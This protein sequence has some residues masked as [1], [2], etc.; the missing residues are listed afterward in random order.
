MEENCVLQA[1]LV[2]P[3]TAPSL[4]LFRSSA[5]LSGLLQT[6]RPEGAGGGRCSQAV[7]LKLG[8]GGGG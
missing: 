8:S 7:A 1:A 2:S 5:L 6:S 4:T 3:G